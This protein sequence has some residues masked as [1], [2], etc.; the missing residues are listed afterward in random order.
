MAV[1][2]QFK[3]LRLFEGAQSGEGWHKVQKFYGEKDIEKIPDPEGVN[4]K[5][6]ITSIPSP[7]ARIHIFEQAYRYVSNH[8]ESNSASLDDSSIFHKLVSDSLDLAEMFFKFDLFNNDRRSLRIVKWNFN[9]DLNKLKTSSNEKHVLLGE[10]LDLYLQQD[11]SASNLNLTEN[12]HFLYCDDILVGGTSPSTL[13]FTTANDL[14]EVNISQGNLTFF[15]ETPCPLYRRDLS[16]QKYIYAL[17][18]IYED[19]TFRMPLVWKYLT[20]NLK[21]LKKVNGE[22]FKE[23]NNILN[24][25]ELKWEAFTEEFERW[26]G[27]NIIDIFPEIE[28]AKK[29]MGIIPGGKVDSDFLIDSQKVHGSSTPL[30]LQNGFK[31]KL[32][33]FGTGLWDPDYIVPYYDNKPLKERYLPGQDEN[34]P[35]LTVSDFLEPFL[36]EVPYPLDRDRFFDGNPDGFSLGDKQNEEPPDNSYLLPLKKA[37]FDYF[38]ISDLSGR[39]S[40]NKPTLRMLKVGLDSVRVELRIP[41]KAQGEH[42][43]FSRLYKPGGAADE[44]KNQGAILEWKFS[45][46]FL[47]FYGD[48]TQLEQRVGLIDMER[49][50]SDSP[51]DFDL[52][53]YGIF[54]DKACNAVS[55]SQSTIRSNRAKGH[56]HGASSKYFLLKDNYRFIEISRKDG[57]KGI[58]IPKFPP[59]QHGSKRFTFAIDFGTTNTHVEYAV[60]DLNPRP[61]DIS[62]AY[63]QMI[64]C[65]DN[66]WGIDYAELEALLK[67]ELVPYEIGGNSKY[68]FPQRTAVSEIEGLNHQQAIFSIGDINVPFHYEKETTLKNEQIKTNLKWT[69]LRGPDSTANENR[70]KSFIE[71]LLILIRNKVILEGGSLEKTNLI[72]FFP[73]SMSVNQ[74]SRYNEIWTRLYK[75]HINPNGNPVSYSESEVP[76]YNHEPDKVS[77]YAKPVVSIDIGGGT[78]DIVVFKDDQPEFLTSVKFAGNTVFG[79]GYNKGISS[80]NG[81]VQVL[82]PRVESFLNENRS[83]VSQLNGVFDQ[84]SVAGSAD[85]MA[86]FFSLSN[87]KELKEKHLEFRVSDQLANYNE[88]NFVLIVFIGSIVYHIAKLMNKLGYEMP[89]SI[90]LSG[91][92]AKIVRLLDRSPELNNLS[93]LCKK[94]FEKVYSQ[95]GSSQSYHNLG[96]NIVMGIDPKQATCKG[97]IQKFRLSNQGSNDAQNGNQNTIGKVVLLGDQEGTVI[98][99]KS[100]KFPINPM[101]YSVLDKEKENSVLGELGVFVDLLFEIHREFNFQE[102]F[103]VNTRDLFTYKETLLLRNEDNMAHGLKDRKLDSS[104]ND[105]IA[106]SLF[107]Y[108]L[109]GGIYSLTQKIAKELLSS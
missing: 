54:P 93:D 45:L 105:D 68:Y 64:P 28:H 30:V 16:F 91:N 24:S 103:G 27:D 14:S 1:E 50:G 9:T 86:F 72:W 31:R 11:G 89:S 74:V 79:D 80:N 62:Q 65:Y 52:G 81:F 106:E 95:D 94:I 40:D 82:K 73:S 34:Y 53:F 23:I 85:I 20:A 7:F 66:F 55:P 4:M 90:C 75:A 97:G 102:H 33:Y 12:L 58:L 100:P 35:Y 96:L 48:N 37:Y 67:R 5:K 83:V 36:I 43:L 3:I 71:T 26:D 39:T 22:F 70:V 10:T 13:F 60:D 38:N 108:P 2:N 101:N 84:L 56:D 98:N 19:L 61:F 44:S 104:D 32:K 63:Q 99:T 92:G 59:S 41:I 57:A 76:F 15:D 17:F 49:P 46:G 21:E 42:I 107:F 87:N 29:R 18:S 8:A 77:S 6:E 25:D 109:V 88:L 78:T 69:K 51:T 47:P